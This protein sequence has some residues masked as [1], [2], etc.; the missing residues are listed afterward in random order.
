MM[1]DKQLERF[2]GDFV[3][4]AR[5]LK[6]ATEFCLT[7]CRERREN[8]SLSVKLLSTILLEVFREIRE[9]VD[10]YETEY[11]S[12]LG[13]SYNEHVEKIVQWV[14]VP[15]INSISEQ[16]PHDSLDNAIQLGERLI[17]SWDSFPR[18]TSD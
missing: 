10:Y 13:V 11:S 4:Q 1:E 14:L 3:D 8:S 16:G 7:F 5:N 15:F 17:V 12:K 2:L 9:Y 18:E 6:S